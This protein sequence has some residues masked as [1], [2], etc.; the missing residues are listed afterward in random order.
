MNVDIV[1]MLDKIQYYKFSIRTLNVK[2]YFVRF[3]KGYFLKVLF[4]YRGITSFSTWL[5]KTVVLC[6]LF[7]HLLIYDS[8]IERQYL[9][10]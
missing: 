7:C 9:T 2:C 8:F 10:V 4:C 6:F 3:L 1:K 5:W